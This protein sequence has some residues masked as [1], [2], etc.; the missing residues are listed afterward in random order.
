MRHYDSESDYVF[1]SFSDKSE[2][3]ETYTNHAEHGEHIVYWCHG[4]I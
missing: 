1:P 4:R 3:L 2:N